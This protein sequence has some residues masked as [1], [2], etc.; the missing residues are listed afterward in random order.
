[1]LSAIP[2]FE[3]EYSSSV[4]TMRLC[5]R[6]L[7]FGVLLLLPL[8]DVH[9]Q[10]EALIWYF[11]NNAGLDFTTVPPSVR[12]DGA[13]NTMEGCASICNSSGRLLFYTN[14]EVVWNARHEIMRDGG[15]LFGDVS[16]TQSAIILPIPNDN[17]TYYIFTVDN[18]A[19]P[20]GLRAHIVDMDGE[21]GLGAVVQRNE[22][23][24]TPTRVVEKLAVVR[25]T[26]RTDYWLIVHG[27]DNNEF[28]SFLITPTEIS[29]VPVVSKAGMV[30]ALGPNNLNSLGAMKASLDGKRLAVGIYG[31]GC[32]EVLDFDPS[33]GIVSPQNPITLISPN[34][35]G[36][37]GV[38]FS[39]DGRKL[40]GSAQQTGNV[41][42]FD[43]TLTSPQQMVEQAVVIDT[44]T[45]NLP[46]SLQLAPNGQI[47]C[48]R[49]AS[50]SID[51]IVYPNESG[52]ACD[53][54]RAAITLTPGISTLGLPAFYNRFMNMEF[55]YHN[56]CP[57]DSTVFSIV[58]EEGI[59]SVLWKFGD[60]SSGSANVSTLMHPSH[61]YPSSGSF[62][63]T[64]SV[65]RG[66]VTETAV[67]E[68]VIHQVPDPSL[69][70]DT[71][72]CPG[73]T[74]VL[75]ADH[76][77]Y[78]LREWSTGE[79]TPSISI[80]KPGVYWVRLS[81]KLCTIADTVVVLPAPEWQLKTM[82]DTTV[83]TGTSVRL[84]AEGGT[85]YQ[86][87]P[88]EGLDN[89]TSATPL[90]QPIA[91][92]TYT[93]VGKDKFGC[94]HESSFT[95]TVAPQPSVWLGKDT[96]LCSGDIL[97]LD[98][99]TQNPE[100]TYLWSTGET[101]RS[102]TAASAG[103]YWVAVRLGPCETSDTINIKYLNSL[104]VVAMAD[105]TICLGDSIELRA[106]GATS[107]RWFSEQG[108]I[109]P[110]EHPP[111]VRPEQTTVYTVVGTSDGGCTS[112]A[113]VT[114]AVNPSPLVT[115]SMP[116]LAATLGSRDVQ[117]PITISSSEPLVLPS[118]KLTVAFR[119]SCLLPTG[120]TAGTMTD[121]SK[122]EEGSVVIDLANLTLSPTPHIATAIRGDI[123]MGLLPSTPLVATVSVDELCIHIATN[124][125][126]LVIQ[127][128]GVDERAVVFLSSTS[129]AVSPNPADEYAEMQ[130]TSA[131]DG[132][133][134][135]DIYSLQGQRV[136]HS[137]VQL[138]AGSRK[139]L[140]VD[141]SL[142][143]PGLYKV[144]LLAGPDTAVTT[145]LVQQ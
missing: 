39:P 29:P 107:Y 133:G 110:T 32:F 61:L 75:H 13:M 68:V 102:I 77:D 138:Q 82:P 21:D 41:Y 143:A 45:L 53:F 92:T 60:Q 96:A 30:H 19:Q 95:V 76:P 12:F 88:T 114:I 59:T 94:A 17:N 64:L 118:M 52:I 38:E 87:T 135:V 139:T 50:P 37:Y 9:A 18:E 142:L 120:A 66:G 1:M 83:C 14:G 6:L 63:V 111:V 74:M 10:K 58:D 34:F 43:L 90:A 101:S 79:I 100:A 103:A 48:A 25:H 125:G 80:N 132:A 33:S 16:A 131:S 117:I 46:G 113:T 73:G 40:Y 98:A 54:Q 15:D 86:W 109:D 112:T 97:T 127:G 49:A 123:L 136:W 7:L 89:P 62:T 24:T 106:G 130:L 78:I 104:A 71:A 116:V 44:N 36:A 57:G 31:A 67:R 35:V 70:A 3:L 23:I 22:P 11:G 134:I 85:T 122:G 121:A 8:L 27:W 28:Y 126:E 55:V 99:G 137:D 47:Y 91:T 105:T 129:V 128:C 69:P 141:T 119:A 115:I 72:L 108:A 5:I 20:R 42:Q 65:Q 124:D 51:A 4:R 145:L 81:D 56:T 2:R 26:N 140:L 93:V 84:R 144:V